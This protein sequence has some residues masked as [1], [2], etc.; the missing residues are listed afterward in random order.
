[1]ITRLQWVIIS[2]MLMFACNSEDKP[3]PVN[4]IVEPPVTNPQ[5]GSSSS[6]GS[7]VSYEHGLAGKVLLYI[8][9][10]N[11]ITLRLEQFTMTQGPDVHV[12]LS[13]SSNYS[14]ANVLEVTKLTTGF[15]GSS[16]NFTFHD[17]RYTAAHVFVLVY[18][19]QYNSLF[20]YAEL[21]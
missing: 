12:Y 4:T 20:G 14:A 10:T 2:S 6:A 5:A 8:D 15:Q 17:T 3:Q 21:Q 11:V 9:T 16:I 7:F 19:N 1:M 18:C 13:K